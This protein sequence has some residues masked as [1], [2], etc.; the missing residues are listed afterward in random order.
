MVNISGVIL[1]LRSGKSPITDDSE[2]LHSLCQ[3]LELIFSKGLKGKLT[4]RTC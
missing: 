2:Q 1:E 3:T 4:K